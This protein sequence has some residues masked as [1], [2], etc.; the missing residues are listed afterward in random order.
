VGWYMA[1]AGV[2]SLLAALPGSRTPRHVTA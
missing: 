1:A 2:L